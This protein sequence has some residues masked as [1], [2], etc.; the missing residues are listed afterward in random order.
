MLRAASGS[1]GIGRGAI[2]DAASRE[3]LIVRFNSL[4]LDAL[5]PEGSG[6]QDEIHRQ[7]LIRYRDGAIY[8]LSDP[9]AAIGWS[10]LIAYDFVDRMRRLETRWSCDPDRQSAE[11]LTRAQGEPQPA[12]PPGTPNLRPDNPVGGTNSGFSRGS[13]AAG[14][15]L[16][17]AISGRDLAFLSAFGVILLGGLFWLYRRRNSAEFRERE[18]RQMLSKKVTIKM[19]RTQHDAVLVDMSM[20]GFKLQHNGCVGKVRKLEIFLADQ[21]H[22]GHIRWRNDGFAGVRFGRPVSP[23]TLRA[24]ARNGFDALI[25]EGLDEEPA[26]DV[27][28]VDA[29]P[30]SASDTA[31]SDHPTQEFR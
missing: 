1:N 23:D 21:W 25:D 28:T 2:L 12:G 22:M 30:Y 26:V 13:V 6:L 16:N 27:T 11:A 3:A 15:S 7:A 24:T 10:A 18:I 31:A 14:S 8:R 20:N 29:A 9:N 4:G 17:S 19:G 5:V